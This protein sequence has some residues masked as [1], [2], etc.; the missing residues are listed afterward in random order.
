[1]KAI[2]QRHCVNHQQTLVLELD[3]H[4]LQREPLHVIAEKDKSRERAQLKCVGEFPIL[5]DNISRLLLESRRFMR[6]SRAA[7]GSIAPGCSPNLMPPL[8][9]PRPRPQGPGPRV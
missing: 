1:V 8:T 5:S 2:A 7:S 9:E 3:T 4:H 6:Y